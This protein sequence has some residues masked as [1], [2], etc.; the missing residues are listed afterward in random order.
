[1]SHS[2]LRFRVPLSS[3]TTSTEINF[4]SLVTT[5]SNNNDQRTVHQSS[6]VTKKKSKK[7]NDEEEEE[8][9]EADSAEDVKDGVTFDF[10]SLDFTNLEETGLQGHGSSNMTSVIERIE[11]SYANPLWVAPLSEDEYD[12]DE[13]LE[14]LVGS[15]EP[16]APGNITETTTETATGAVATGTTKNKKKRKRFF[17]GIDFYDEDDDFI[18]DS[19]LIAEKEEAYRQKKTTNKHSGFFVN[20]GEIVVDEDSDLDSDEVPQ[21][22]KTKVPKPQKR[23]IVKT[24][25]ARNDFIAQHLGIEWVGH[26]QLLQREMDTFTNLALTHMDH[27]SRRLPDILEQPLEQ[28]D[29]VVRS[30]TGKKEWR[31]YPYIAALLRALPGFSKQNVIKTLKRLEKRSAARV[32]MR[33]FATARSEF[34]AYIKKRLTQQVEEDDNDKQLQQENKKFKWDS[35]SQLLLYKTIHTMKQ[36]IDKENLYRAELNKHDLDVLG[37][38]ADEWIDIKKEKKLLLSSLLL[39]WSNC[40]K[41]YSVGINDKLLREHAGNG[42]KVYQEENRKK[43]KVKSD[44]STWSKAMKQQVK[45]YIERKGPRNPKSS[46]S[47][48]QSNRRKAGI[49]DSVIAHEWKN[50]D[51]D[52]RKVFDLLANQDQNR[53]SEEYGVFT[54]NHLN[55]YINELKK[56]HSEQMEQQQREDVNVRKRK[57]GSRNSSKSNKNSKTGS[58]GDLLDSPA[59]K[60]K[61]EQKIINSERDKKIKNFLK[62]KGPTK[63]RNSYVF[64][65]LPRRTELT[66]ENPDLNGKVG[67]LSKILGEEWRNFS[68]EEKQKYQKLAL[69]D[70]ERYAKEMIIFQPEIDKFIEGGMIL[71]KKVRKKPGRKKK[72]VDGEEGSDDDEDDDG[73]GSSSKNSEE[74][75][76]PMASSNFSEMEFYDDDFVQINRR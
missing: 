15:G 35:K 61:R 23:N 57:K 20:S 74:K 27:S 67:E 41:S 46:Y 8:A 64:F 30:S 55:H 34:S 11:R 3:K 17:R 26:T 58:R 48:F 31:P 18:D 10:D 4:Q 33:D 68:A 50:I 53:F 39:L 14:N 2:C 54:K 52:E 29:V 19:E 38:H 60:S 51:D 62:S 9:E 70:R 65:A 71:E 28:L 56:Q 36:W 6:N 49:G 12:N 21:I 76:L 43:G 32:L 22:K 24:G 40:P 72:T 66:K 1:M 69:E 7:S 44:R 47:F 5:H 59:K 42:K 37:F 45:S 25:N 63:P 73:S 13:P 75:R 16:G